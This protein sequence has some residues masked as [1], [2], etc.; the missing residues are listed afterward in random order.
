MRELRDDDAQAERLRLA[1]RIW[2]EV[3]FDAAKNSGRLA[4]I[5]REI[6]EKKNLQPAS[7][8]SFS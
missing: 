4:E 2:V 7:A 6:T 3:N 1:A 8:L 5:Y